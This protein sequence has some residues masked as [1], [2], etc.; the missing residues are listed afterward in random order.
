MKNKLV[1]ASFVLLFVWA[2]GILGNILNP[3]KAPVFTSANPLGITLLAQDS[4]VDAQVAPGIFTFTAAGT[5]GSINLLQ[6]NVRFHRFTWH[7][8]GTLSACQLGVQY[9]NDNS[10]WTTWQSPTDCT[11]PSEFML[12]GSPNYV[13]VH[14]TTLTG[15][16][17]PTVYVSYRGYADDPSGSLAQYASIASVDVSTAGLTQVVA[18]TTRRAFAVGGIVSVTGAGTGNKII[19]YQGTGSNCAA[20]GAGITG[21]VVLGTSGT[22]HY[23][24]E[25]FQTTVDGRAI[26]IQTDSAVR[27]QGYLRYYAF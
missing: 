4:P 3:E 1:N 5:G 22:L 11:V 10:T 15:S 27:V 18:L 7:T 26:C 17:T 2:M 12:V 21:G 8:T 9:S 16:S 24:I 13:R 20:N 25:P 6:T 19:W 23:T 14:A